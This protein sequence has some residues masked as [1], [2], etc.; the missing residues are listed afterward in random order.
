MYKLLI[1]GVGNILMADDGLGVFI[2]K[3]LKQTFNNL[4]NVK[5]LDVG[6]SILNFLYEI[7]YTENLIVIDAIRGGKKPGTVYRINFTKENRPFGFTDSHGFS[8]YEVLEFTRG[9]WKRPKKVI[10]YGIEVL[11]CKPK[12]GLSPIVK[13][14]IP[15][16]LLEIEREIKSIL[17]NKS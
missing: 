13:K 11:D 1:L 12:I 17:I 3:K 9:L 6:T 4:G 14:S 7:K 2:A 16:M 15:N 5:I 8:L 10:I